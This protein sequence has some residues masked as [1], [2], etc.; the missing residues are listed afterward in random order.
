MFLSA[1]EGQGGGR[2]VPGRDHLIPHPRQSKP[3]SASSLAAFGADHAAFGD[4]RAGGEQ[5]KGRG[6]PE[7]GA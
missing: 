5:G 6:P 1:D 4:H 7:S 3:S 2:K